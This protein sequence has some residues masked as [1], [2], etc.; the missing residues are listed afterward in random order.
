MCWPYTLVYSCWDCLEMG[1]P[2]WEACVVVRP[3]AEDPIMGGHNYEGW[4]CPMRYLG[5]PGGGSPTRASL[6]RPISS[7]KP[8]RCP[9][10]YRYKPWLEAAGR[11]MVDM[12]SPGLGAYTHTFAFHSPQHR[13]W[14]CPEHRYKYLGLGPEYMGYEMVRDL[15]RVAA[16]RRREEELREKEA[17]MSMRE[18][19]KGSREGW[20]M[21]PNP[22]ERGQKRKRADSDSMMRARARSSQLSM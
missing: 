14:V 11:A 19:L 10:L 1:R 20:E 6:P 7:L 2:A 15:Q 4:P 8:L 9:T 22:S 17:A 16:R 18:Y 3:E 13:Y 12:A 21:T 5:S